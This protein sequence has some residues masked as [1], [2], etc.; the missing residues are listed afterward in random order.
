MPRTFVTEPTPTIAPVI[1]CVV[2]TGMCRY[3]APNSVIAPARFAQNPPG[4][5]SDVMPMPSR[6]DDALA[7]ERGA[8]RH[9][10]VRREDRPT[11]ARRVELARQV[12]AATM[13]SPDHADRLLRVVA[14]V[15]D[16]VRGRRE[17]LADAERLIDLARPH[18][19]ER[20]HQQEHRDHAEH[21]A[22]DRRER[23]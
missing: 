9:R 2:E 14:A 23:R 10:A 13:H 5:L 4:G 12:P 7:A 3:V 15:A 16:R 8:E 20:P 19:P 21:E 22:D 17:Q 18:A 1:V 11:P 6:L